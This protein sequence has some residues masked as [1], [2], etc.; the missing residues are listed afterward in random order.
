MN[1]P[2]PHDTVVP[3]R[4]S[5]ETKK[6]QVARMFDRIAP[7]Y[8]LANH[9]LSCGMDF[10][11]RRRAVVSSGSVFSEGPYAVH[12][13]FV[14]SIRGILGFIGLTDVEIIRVEGTANPATTADV[15]AAAKSNIDSMKLLQTN[16]DK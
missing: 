10:G 6:E 7:R 14:P 1:H 11:W 16:R 15:V 2:L 12:D 8:D 13:H 5:A 3:D 9:L 4:N